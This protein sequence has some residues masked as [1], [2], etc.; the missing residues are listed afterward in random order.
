M[1]NLIASE[2][3]LV[4]FLLVGMWTSLWVFIEVA[5]KG[6]GHLSDWNYRRKINRQYFKESKEKQ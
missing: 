3:I 4:Y 1:K 5:F 6:L 2:L